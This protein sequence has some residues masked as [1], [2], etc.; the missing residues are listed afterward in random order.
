M[1]IFITL[2]APFIFLFKLVVTYIAVIAKIDGVQMD[3]LS[4]YY[5][6][7][8]HQ[9]LQAPRGRCAPN[10][11]V[12]GLL[13]EHGTRCCDID[14]RDNK[15][16]DVK[17]ASPLHCFSTLEQLPSLKTFDFCANAKE[18]ISRISSFGRCLSSFDCDF[19]SSVS[20]FSSCVELKDILSSPDVRMTE[21]SLETANSKSAHIVFVG[22]PFEVL[23]VLSALISK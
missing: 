1:K 11:L 21:F 18:F 14:A 15:S 2:V 22:S 13:E 6:Y 3:T 4:T 23:K 10:S 7:L 9:V 16:S 12:D 20:N 5:N 17:I 19:Q 8:S